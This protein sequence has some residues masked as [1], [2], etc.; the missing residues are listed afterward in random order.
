MKRTLVFSNPGYLSVS[1]HQL[2][3]KDKETDVER[4]VPLEDIGIVIVESMQIALSMPL[5]VEFAHSGIMLVVCG[6][7]HM[8]V[9]MLMNLD[10]NSKQTLVI[11]NQLEVSLPLKKQL[12]QQTA[13]RKIENQAALLKK[14]NFKWQ[15]VRRLS[16]EVLSDDSTNRE[17]LAA[18]IYWGRLFPL[19]DF[20]RDPDGD[21]PNNFLNYG[22]SILRAATARALSGSGLLPIV[23]IHHRSQ[24]NPFCL[25]DDIMEP[26]RPFVDEV[27][28][29]LVRMYPD[30][31]DLN[32]VSKE[33]LLQGL[34]CDVSFQDHKR[35]LLLGLSET[36]ASLAR[37]FSKEDRVII[38]PNMV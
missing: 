25:A 6:S 27:V 33:R 15:D 35:P 31:Q 26:Y 2:T 12:W 16:T 19:F 10:E 11:R 38:F 28:V 4:T 18:K 13:R 5:M 29:D 9:S 34:C 7:N 17:G 1:L 23:G 3:Y 21:F 14:L 24:Y 20:S 8:P 30:E 22:Y 37:C 32:R 36:T